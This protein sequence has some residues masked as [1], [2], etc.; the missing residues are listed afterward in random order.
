MAYDAP[1]TRSQAEPSAQA[2]TGHSPLTPR[3]KVEV[4]VLYFYFTTPEVQSQ[5]PTSPEFMGSSSD[6]CPS[7]LLSQ[8]TSGPPYLEDE[9]KKDLGRQ[10]LGVAV[11]A[12]STDSGRKAARRVDGS[13]SFSWV[14]S[15]ETFFA[16]SLAK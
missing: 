11:V 8:V 2:S 3:S 16:L 5:N 1:A 7:L 9:G 10:I 12:S 13:D 6:L 14:S 15:N 4:E